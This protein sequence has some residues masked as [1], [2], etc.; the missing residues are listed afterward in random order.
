MTIGIAPV[1]IIFI[2]TPNINKSDSAE[3]EINAI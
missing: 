2:M 1:S 3:L